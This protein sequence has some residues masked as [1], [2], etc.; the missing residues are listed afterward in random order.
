MLYLGVELSNYSVSIV[1]LADGFSFLGESC[2]GC[3]SRNQIESWIRSFLIDDSE[4]IAFFFS[5]KE[6]Q[7]H[8]HEVLNIIPSS[9]ISQTWYLVNERVLLNIYHILSDIFSAL[10]KCPFPKSYILAA[11]N[12]FFERRFIKEF[13]SDMQPSSIA[14]W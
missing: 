14:E 11:S 13:Y 8:E 10:N 4:S 7:S 5:S 6:F 12:R 9:F 1:V 2:F 3:D